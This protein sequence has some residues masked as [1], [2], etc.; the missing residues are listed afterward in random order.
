MSKLVVG[1]VALQDILSVHL[2]HG[3][4]VVNVG[5]VIITLGKDAVDGIVSAQE[6]RVCRPI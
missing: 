5:V 4:S 6:C 3:V 2:M 1:L